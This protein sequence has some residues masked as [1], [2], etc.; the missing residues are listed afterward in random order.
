[1]YG[2]G[3]YGGGMYGNQTGAM[4]GL[5]QFN[6]YLFSV[7]QAAQMIEYNANGIGAFSM[8]IKRFATW[9][10]EASATTVTYLWKKFNEWYKQVKN[11][12]ESGLFSSDNKTIKQLHDHVEI[13]EKMLNVFRWLTLIVLIRIAYSLFKKVIWAK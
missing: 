12:R 11:I 10:Y 5:N 2:G 6:Q 13:L 8:L 1:M 9:L 3:M 4:G 7:C